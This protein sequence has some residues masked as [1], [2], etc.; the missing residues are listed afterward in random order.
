M[1]TPDTEKFSED[2][3]AGKLAFGASAM[4]GWRMS[5]EDS[6]IALPAI[7]H[8]RGLFAVFDGHGGSEVALFCKKHMPEELMGL[9]E[10]KDKKFDKALIR[11]FHRMDDLIA[12]TENG[13]ELEMLKHERKS[14]S[15]NSNPTPEGKRKLERQLKRR[16]HV[17]PDERPA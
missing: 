12:N 10:Y 6:H 3:A 2:G 5:M 8:D 14:A 13:D 9:E 17:A 1:S 7:D 15:G 16:H 11:V 4:Q